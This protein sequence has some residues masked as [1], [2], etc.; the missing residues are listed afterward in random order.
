MFVEVPDSVPYAPDIQRFMEHEYPGLNSG[1]T[2]S[3]VDAISTEIVGTGQVR[4]GSKPNPE[5]LVAIRQVIRLHVDAGAPIPVLVPAGPKKPVDTH[6]VDMAEL[7]ALKML[8]CLNDRVRQYYPAGINYRI[9]LEDV[10]GWFLEGHIPTTRPAIERYLA[11]FEML[12]RIMGYDQAII[13]VR[14]STMMTEREF[15]ELSLQIAAPMEEYVRAT[16]QSFD[17]Y[18]NLPSW[19]KLVELGWKGLIPPEQRNFYRERFTKLIPDLDAAGVERHMV[20]YL[21]STLARIKLNAVGSG[22]WS[23]W[24]QLNFAPPVP[25]IPTSMVSTRVHY[26]TAPLRMTKRHLPYWR[27]KGFLKLNDDVRIALASWTEP[28]ELEPC[29]VKLHKGSDAVEVAADYMIV[30]EHD[31]Q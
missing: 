13:P 6:S 31:E 17:D 22:S 3:L 18:E 30:D 4:Y 7:S 1:T 20:K 19:Q 12:I 15:S 9:R 16:D 11:D 10:T 26:R 23:K 21:A 14:E 27:A 29:S 24:I 28:L 2:E 8:G 5:S 25:G